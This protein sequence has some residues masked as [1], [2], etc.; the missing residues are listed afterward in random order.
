MT[1]FSIPSKLI[2]KHL[3]S[4]FRFFKI[5]FM[6]PEAVIPYVHFFAF[7]IF[8]LRSLKP[9]LV[10]EKIIVFKQK[11]IVANMSHRLVANMSY[12][13]VAN[14][15]HRLVAN[16]SHRLVANMSYTL[17][18]RSVDRIIQTLLIRFFFLFG[19]AN[20]LLWNFR[21]V[22]VSAGFASPLI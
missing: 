1:I 11:R 15:S 18:D 4:R 22:I 17:Q 21:K 20:S 14:M 9:S 19:Y 7:S 13:L 10:M 12:R 16:M 5:I 6:P 8:F 3:L 2:D